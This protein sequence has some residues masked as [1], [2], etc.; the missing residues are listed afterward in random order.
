MSPTNR[1][2]SLRYVRASRESITA[3][4]SHVVTTG[5]SEAPEATSD[6]YRE[7][8]NKNSIHRIIGILLAKHCETNNS[9]NCL[10]C[11]CRILSFY[12]FVGL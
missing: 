9:T 12:K 11:S 2:T 8:V 7:Q 6:M 5:G 10:F 1:E 3:K 4:L